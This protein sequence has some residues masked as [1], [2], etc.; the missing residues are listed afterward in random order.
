M[1]DHIFIAIGFL[2]TWCFLSFHSLTSGHR[3]VTCPLRYREHKAV[4]FTMLMICMYFLNVM[5]IVHSLFFCFSEEI[6]LSAVRCFSSFDVFV[7]NWCN[8]KST[9]Q[10]FRLAL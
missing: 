9:L 10:K 6:P 7:E 4:A 1:T 8:Q 5:N 2:F 3:L